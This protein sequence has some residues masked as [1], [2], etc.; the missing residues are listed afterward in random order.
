MVGNDVVDLRDR[1]ARG[2][3]APRFDARVFCADELESLAASGRRSR[4]RWRLWAAK[5]AAY[6]VAVKSDPSTVFSPSRFRVLLEEGAGDGLVE[7]P[8]SEEKVP[9][10]L[11]E[12][13]GA[14]HAVARN[15]AAPLVVGILRSG[16]GDLSAEVRRFAALRLADELR[17]SPDEIEIR[18]RGR[19]PELWLGGAPAPVDLSLSHHGGVVAFACELEPG[20]PL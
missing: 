10:H 18:K 5:E 20:G 3:V 15:G 6:K 9:V 14:V 8:G 13:D 19:I 4:R 12:E 1:D 2:E 7:V 17:V 11:C 16:P